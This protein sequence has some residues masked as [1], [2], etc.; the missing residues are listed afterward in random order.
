MTFCCLLRSSY[1]VG[2]WVVAGLT[3]TALSACAMSVTRAGSEADAADARSASANHKSFELSMMNDGIPLE[4]SRGSAVKREKSN[5]NSDARGG[6]LAAHYHRL[7]ERTHSVQPQQSL[8]P[9]RH[10]VFAT[11][12]QKVAARAGRARIGTFGRSF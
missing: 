5:S 8:C 4:V 7:E 6:V 11:H 2:P 1:S 10:L 12:C 9:V 3:S